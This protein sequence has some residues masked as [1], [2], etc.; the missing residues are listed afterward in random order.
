LIYSPGHDSK[1]TNTQ[2]ITLFFFIMTKQVLTSL[3]AQGNT[4]AEILSILDAIVAEQSSEQGYAE[5][6]ADVIDF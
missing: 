6:T 4:G 1:L 2:F 3:L 5:P